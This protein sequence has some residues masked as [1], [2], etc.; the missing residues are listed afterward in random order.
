MTPFSFLPSLQPSVCSSCCVILG[1]SSGAE[2][3]LEAQQAGTQPFMSKLWVLFG[4]CGFLEV[5]EGTA[6]QEW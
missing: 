2:T 3:S 6:E 1:S 4:S 5:G